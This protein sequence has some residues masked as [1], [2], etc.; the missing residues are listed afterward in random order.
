MNTPSIFPYSSI[1]DDPIRFQRL[2]WPDIRLYDKQ[3]EILYSLRDN[4]ETI[5]PAGN[6][7]GKDF[8]AGIG[9]LWFFCS[10]SPVRIVTSSVDGSQLEGVLWGEIR[11]F[12]QSSKL[13]LPIRVNH[14]HI[15]QVIDGR[16]EPRSELTGRVVK[17]GEGLLGR[18]I[19]LTKDRRPRT[20]VVFDEASA[21]DDICYDTSDTWAHRK[22]I[23]GNPYPCNNFFKRFTT[24]GDVVDPHD[25]SRFYRRVIRIK[26]TDSPNVRRAR[27]LLKL[28]PKIDRLELLDKAELVPG[29]IGYDLYEKRRN[30]W[31]KVRQCIGLDGEFYEG[32]ESLLYPPEWLNRAEIIAA[33]LNQTVKNRKAVSLGVDPGE[34]GAKTVWTIVDHLGMIEQISKVTP[35][36]SEIPNTTIALINEY[37]L[38]HNQVIFDRGG[39]GRQHA[40][41]LR[42]KGYNVRTV[43]FGETVVPDLVR[44]YTVGRRLKEKQASREERYVYKNRRAQ[45]Y[46]ILRYDLLDPLNEDGF[47]IPAK[48]VE[49]RRQLS[50]LPLTYDGEGRLYLPPKA[51]RNPASTEKTIIDL[52][53]HSPDEADSLVL[54]T[55]GLFH[56]HKRRKLK[57]S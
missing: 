35:D 47:G 10:R 23:I 38:E 24:D 45:M 50:I 18:H 17:R 15:R 16:L 43:A 41:Y 26:A 34:G 44:I 22:L 25:S 14:L 30:L 32:A 21:I 31:D 2:C 6:D 51:K 11:R 8:L 27:H 5:V 28:N 13:P 29:V 56:S 55:F 42:R 19:E 46:G 57:A 48:Y 39:G 1:L 7:L 49:L 37:S 4:D 9:V 33:E 20:L 12:I 40:D 54:A 53:G 36:T 3:A 52:V